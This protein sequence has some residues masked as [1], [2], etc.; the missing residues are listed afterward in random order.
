[1]IENILCDHNLI[2]FN[3]HFSHEVLCQS[4]QNPDSDLYPDHL[5]SFVVISGLSTNFKNY[6]ESMWKV[7]F[8]KGKNVLKTH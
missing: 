6:G 8:S 3:E 1:M 5:L 2:S 7:Y 4:H